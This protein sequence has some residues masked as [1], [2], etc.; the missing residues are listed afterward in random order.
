M[1]P[2]GKKPAPKGKKKGPDTRGVTL[3]DAGR[4]KVKEGELSDEALD[5]VSGG[6]I[7]RMGEDC[8]GKK[9]RPPDP[10]PL[11]VC[12][13]SVQYCTPKK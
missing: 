7:F 10:P 4:F 8:K 12:C 6:T 9:K 11:N 2:K 13:P 1:A 3:D 5:G